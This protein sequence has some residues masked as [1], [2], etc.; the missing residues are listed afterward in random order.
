LIDDLGNRELREIIIRF[1]ESCEPLN[2]SNCISRLNKRLKYC[3]VI[4]QECDFIAS[5][6]SEFHFDVI[7]SL[8]VKTFKDILHSDS[9][10]IE[11]A[12][13]LLEF[14]FELGS[15]YSELISLV[16]FEYLT[17]SSIGRFCEHMYFS[18]LTSEI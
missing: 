9:L 8:D 3:I 7:R 1:G 12:A 4:D 6:F 13:W 10:P 18:A 16:R 5:H 15:S 2:V 17:P 11:N 14:L